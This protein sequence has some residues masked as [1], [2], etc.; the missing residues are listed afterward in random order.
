[1]NV[2]Y[3]SD[4]LLRQAEDICISRFESDIMLVFNNF[5]DN[6]ILSITDKIKSDLKE[7][8][9]AGMLMDIP[10][11]KVFC[12]MYLGLAWSMYGKGKL[13]QKEKKV[14][15]DITESKNEVNSSNDILKLIEN[16]TFYVDIIDEI[17]IRY[18]TLYLSK[19][20]IDLFLRMNIKRDNR[21]SN[22]GDLQF[23]IIEK[24]KSFG[25][26]ILAKGIFEEYK[27]SI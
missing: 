11:V 13:L 21:I 6:A 7:F 16:N 17:A 19:Y 5:T 2:V 25:L 23:L 15:E 12:S 18:Y 24:L 8:I 4:Y 9:D 3:F 26:K 27:K 14:V 10:I 1:M 20:I 22:F